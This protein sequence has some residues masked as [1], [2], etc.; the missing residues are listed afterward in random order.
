MILELGL[1]WSCCLR[2]PPWPLPSITAITQQQPV[3]TVT[4]AAHL[5]E[6]RILFVLL[7]TRVIHRDLKGRAVGHRLTERCSSRGS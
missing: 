5:T 6:S 4:P 7:G 3:L 2:V 1:G